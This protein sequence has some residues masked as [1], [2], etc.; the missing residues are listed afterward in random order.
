MGLM[1]RDYMRRRDIDPP[2]VVGRAGPVKLVRK[3]VVRPV[4]GNKVPITFWWRLIPI[5]FVVGFLTRRV[6]EML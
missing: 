2:E 3:S 6:F 5:A 1:D 4:R